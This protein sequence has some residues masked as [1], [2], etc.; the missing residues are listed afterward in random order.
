LAVPL[1]AQ[2]SVQSSP[3]IAVPASPSGSASLIRTEERKVSWELLVPNVLQDQKRIW[4]FPVEV[5]RGRHV[6]P[7]LGFALVTAGIVTLDPHDT[8]YFRRTDSFTGLNRIFSSRKTSA[9]MILFPA[10]F[11]ALGLARK[12][13]YAQDTA[14]LA[15]QAYLDAQI[16]TFALKSATRRIRP[17]DIPV[18]GDFTH[19]W[20]KSDGGVINGQSGF[21][22][23]HAMVAFGIATVFAQR[24]RR[25]RWV[26]WV[27]YGLAGV[28]A[29]SRVPTRSHFPSDAVAGSI[30]GFT[31]ARYVVLRQP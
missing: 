30:L 22:S 2:E 7:A 8:P 16:L 11:Y 5:G 21:P 31:M 27:A 29:F 1:A 15:G 28:V 12:D 9:A 18:D 26:P 20:Y 24:Y 13:R 23:G 14:L 17:R 4:L 19:T 10:S 25:H 3:E 6:K